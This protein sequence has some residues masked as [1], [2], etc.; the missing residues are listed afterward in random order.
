MADGVDLR[1]LTFGIAGGAELPPVGWT[2]GAVAS[3]PKVRSACLVGNAR[4]HAAALAAFDFPERIAA[5]LEVV[6]L[7]VDG[8]AAAAIDENTVIDTG[9]QTVQGGIGRTCLEVDIRHALEGNRRPGIGLTAAVRLLVANHGSLF[10]GGLEVAENAFVDDGEFGCF[11]AIVVVA[12]GSKR[13][14]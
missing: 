10:A 12:D 1:R 4:D 2:G 6:A 7:L 11:D 5:E 14:G 3:L 13:F 9:N 8:I